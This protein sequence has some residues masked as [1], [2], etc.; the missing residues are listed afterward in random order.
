MIHL[1]KSYIAES[2]SSPLVGEKEDIHAFQT[3]GG[4]LLCIV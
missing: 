2:I 3:N 1:G 4:L